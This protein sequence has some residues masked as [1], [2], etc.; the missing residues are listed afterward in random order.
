MKTAVV[1]RHLNQVKNLDEDA[2][3][4]LWELRVARAASLKEMS[5]SSWT[6]IVEAVVV[7]EDVTEYN[8][9]PTCG[10]GVELRGFGFVRFTAL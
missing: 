6:W 8:S 9:C 7:N 3:S 4:P 10:R 1:Y 2:V 5:E